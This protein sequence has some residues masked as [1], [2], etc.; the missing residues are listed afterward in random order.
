MDGMVFFVT[1]GF[2]KFSLLCDIGIGIKWSDGVCFV[3]ILGESILGE[4]KVGVKI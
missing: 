1:G 2:E 3:V 4:G